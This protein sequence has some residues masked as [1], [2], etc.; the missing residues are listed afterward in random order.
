MAICMFMVSFQMTIGRSAE[1]L[2]VTNLTTP[3]EFNAFI[4]HEGTLNVVKF[5]ATWCRHSPFLYSKMGAKLI[6]Q[7]HLLHSKNNY[8]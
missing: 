6:K 3:E 2:L 1:E 4:N 7:H 5:Y 8:H